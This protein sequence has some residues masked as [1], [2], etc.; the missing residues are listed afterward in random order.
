MRYEE[1]MLVDSDVASQM[2]MYCEESFS[3]YKKD[4]VEWDKEVTFSNGFRMAVQ[5]C[6][7]NDVGLEPCWTQ[8]VLFDPNGNEVGCTPPGDDFLGEYMVWD[9]DDEYVANVV[10]E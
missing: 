7:P 3:D 5:V 9:N 4:G 6:G 2:Q 8:G 1:Q 10:S